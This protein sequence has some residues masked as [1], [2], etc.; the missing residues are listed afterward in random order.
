MFKHNEYP[1]HG[2]V[3]CAPKTFKHTVVKRSEKCIELFLLVKRGLKPFSIYIY[4]YIIIGR[5]KFSYIYRVK[6]SWMLTRTF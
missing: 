6:F 2:G 5:V 1:E 4:I 3:I